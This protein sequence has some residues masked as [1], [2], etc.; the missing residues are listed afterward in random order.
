MQLTIGRRLNQTVE[1]FE[2]ASRI[3]GTLRD[4]SHEGSSTFPEGRVRD[5]ESVYR[6]SYNAKVWTNETEWKARTLIFDPYAKEAPR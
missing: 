5:R 3:Y 6:I 4:E 2:E 1:S